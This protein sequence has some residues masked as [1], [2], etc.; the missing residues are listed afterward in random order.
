M[1]REDIKMLVKKWWDIYEDGS[2]DY[3][4]CP[5]AAAAVAAEGEAELVNMEPFITALSEAGTV[6]FVTGPSAA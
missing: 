3:K 4:N 5:Q 6:E 2:L 1:Q